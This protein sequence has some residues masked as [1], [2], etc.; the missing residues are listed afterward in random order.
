MST[1]TSGASWICPQC[2]RR[3]PAYV[4]LCRC[5][6]EIV[7]GDTAATDIPQAVQVSGGGGGRLTTVVLLSVVLLGA[8]IATGMYLNRPGATPEASARTA[9]DPIAPGGST[10]APQ[11]VSAAAQTEASNAPIAADPHP[12]PTTEYAPD[13]RTTPGTPS[14]RGT[15]AAGDL[16]APASGEPPTAI[17]DIVRIAEPAVAVVE[18]PESRGTGFFIGPD[19]VLTNVHVVQ[20]RSAVTV[21]LSGGTAL[22]ARVERT[23]P[24]VDIALLK[25]DRPHPQRAALELGS[26]DAVRAGQEVMAI[27]APLGLQSTVTRGIVSAVRNAGGVMLIQTDAAINPGN[28]GGPLLDRRGRVIG[29]NTMGIRSAE[30]L[31]FAVAIN[32]AM[33]VISNSAPAP[34]VVPP[35]TPAIAMPTTPSETDALRTRGQEKYQHYMTELAQRADQLD[36]TWDNFQRNCLVNPMSVGDA[37]RSWFVLRDT[38][39]TFKAAD[40]WCG[41]RLE[42]VVQSAVAFAQ[43]MKMVGEEARRAGVYPGI[44]REIRRK[45]RLDWTGWER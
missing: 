15:P 42:T 31:G 41:N 3:V 1:T 33:S 39:P 21:R 44:L 43:A 12:V 30:S 7:P 11:G 9:K 2:D 14:G 23:L 35:G 28:S 5:G 37:Q 38:R 16:R 4:R 13:E 17:E 19:S 25:T 26:I 18:T 29:I 36:G 24:A 40:V 32:H 27:G 10:T 8:G 22:A 20:G 45:Y 34:V 6:L